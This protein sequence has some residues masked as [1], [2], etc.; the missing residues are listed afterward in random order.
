MT[1]AKIW[2]YTF[3]AILCI[4]ALCTSCSKQRS[5]SD[6]E[7]AIVFR[8]AF[9]SNAYTSTNGINL[10]SLRLYEPIFEKYGYTTKDVQYT[11]GSF[12]TRKSARL[13]DIVEHSIAMLEL[14]G[15][16]LDREVAVL[17]TIDNIAQ[18]RASYVIYSDSIIELLSW[19]DTSDIFIMLEDLS[20]GNYNIQFDYMVDD[21]LSTVTTYKYASWSEVARPTDNPDSMRYLERNRNS[22]YLDKGGAAKLSKRVK[23]EEDH[24]RL[25]ITLAMPEY[26]KP[27]KRIVGRKTAKQ[28]EEEEEEVI[29][30]PA[31]TIKRLYVSQIPDVDESR[32]ELFKKMIPITIF[33]NALYATTPKDSL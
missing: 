25:F 29:T 31:I 3:I 10:D 28:I 18:R 7:L 32:N 24:S 1:R 6:R 5:L 27:K 21:S 16:I 15:I 23:I 13:G 14:E 30:T 8:D 4:S 22:T 11:I 2:K 20:K 26:V 33:D 17:D 9:L 19:R 12:A